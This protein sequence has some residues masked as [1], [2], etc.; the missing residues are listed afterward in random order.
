MVILEPGLVSG[1][2]LVKAKVYGVATVVVKKEMDVTVVS[3]G[4]VLMVTS[5]T[6]KVVVSADTL[7]ANVEIKMSVVMSSVSGVDGAKVPD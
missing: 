5:G 4:K 7:I 2:V 6:V 3:S 1:S